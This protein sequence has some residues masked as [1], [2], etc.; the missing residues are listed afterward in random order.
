MTSQVTNSELFNCNKKYNVY[1]TD[2]AKGVGGG[3]LIAVNECLVCFPVAIT[4]DIECVW[5]CVSVN[6]KKVVIGCCYRAPSS[7]VTFSDSM[8][9]CLS[10]ISTRFPDAPILLVGDFNFPNISWSGTCPLINPTSAESK[11]FVDICADFSLLQVVTSPTRVTDTTSSLLDLV[12]TS[13]SDI[14]SQVTHSPGLSDHDVLHF[15]ISL[16]ISLSHN[17]LKTIRDY[18][19]ANFTAINHELGVFLDNFLPN[20]AER[21][22]DTNWNMFKEKI[23]DLVNQFIPTRRVLSNNNAPWYTKS[24]KRLSNRKNVSFAQQ[25]G[26]K[27][28]LHGQLTKKLPRPTHLQ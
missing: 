24:L 23:Q 14:I 10:Q 7:A 13:S 9:D 20:A 6:Y 16:S 2:R 18:K 26:P 19:K 5:C 27:T 28:R 21:S 25:S 15:T 22:L 4:C 17:S 3:V 1:R 12:L 11:R 8:Y